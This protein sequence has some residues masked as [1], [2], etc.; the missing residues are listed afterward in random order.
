MRD[1]RRG[2]CGLLLCSMMLLFYAAGNRQEPAVWVYHSTGAQQYPPVHSSRAQRQ[3]SWSPLEFKQ[4]A[5]ANIQANYRRC[6]SHWVLV[7][8][9][10]GGTFR[11]GLSPERRSR[12][13]EGDSPGCV[14]RWGFP[15]RTWRRTTLLVQ[16][17]DRPD[18]A[19][20]KLR[21][22]PRRTKQTPQSLGTRYPSG[23]NN[24]GPRRWFSGSSQT[25]G[26]HES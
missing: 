8:C 24:L 5:R 6:I 14:P 4:A 9:I 10:Y 18:A 16:H 12:S 26:I 22:C 3:N 13:I 23:L 2:R 15:S 19:P 7:C 25:P 20:S 1:V 11:V 17:A 21:C